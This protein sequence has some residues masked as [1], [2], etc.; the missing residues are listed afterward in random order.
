[1]TIES[2]DD[3]RRAVAVG[4]PLDDVVRQ[5]VTG[6][7]PEERLWC[8]DGDAPTWAGLT[9]LGPDGDEARYGVSRPVQR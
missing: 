3:A 5:F 6:L 8:L 4:T 9:F 7:T 1:M 2:F